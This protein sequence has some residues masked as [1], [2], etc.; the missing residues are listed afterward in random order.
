M[1]MQHEQ[2]WQC[3]G[4]GMQHGHRM[5]VSVSVTIYAA[6]ENFGGREKRGGKHRDDVDGRPGQEEEK[7]T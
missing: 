7:E 4:P 1:T 6:G 5:C 2:D 3:N